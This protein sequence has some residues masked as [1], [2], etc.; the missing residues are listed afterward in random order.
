MRTKVRWRYIV[1][2]SNHTNTY[3]ANTSQCVYEMT[4]FVFAKVR[5]IVYFR[6]YQFLQ[7][8]L[9]VCRHHHHRRHTCLFKAV[10]TNQ[11]YITLS[12]KT[13]EKTSKM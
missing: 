3:L 9:E 11:N 12:I 4:C 1:F 10:T 8:R 7:W 5:L 13:Q 2:R 6:R